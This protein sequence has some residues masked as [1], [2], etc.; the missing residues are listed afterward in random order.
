MV[1]GFTISTAMTVHKY[2]DTLADQLLNLIAYRT[3][4]GASK[5]NKLPT[6]ALQHYISAALIGFILI[7]IVIVLTMGV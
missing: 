6:S 2:F 7:L 4:R 5:M 3:L 1:A